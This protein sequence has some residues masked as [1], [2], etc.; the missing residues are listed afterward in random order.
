MNLAPLF[1][2]RLPALLALALSL[3]LAPAAVAADDPLGLPPAVRQKLQ[4]FCERFSHVAPDRKVILEPEWRG[5]P[6][7][8]VIFRRRVVSSDEK[9]NENLPMLLTQN[10]SHVFSG[11]VLKVDDMNP[12]GPEG[13]KALSKFLSEKA[14]DPVEIVLQ[15][16]KN[17]AGV[18]PG[19]M[20]QSA[21]IGKLELEC[22]VTADGKFF[23]LGV[24]Y[25]L[26]GDPRAERMK[27]LKLDG[28]I[29]T[30]PANAPVTIVEFSD[31]ECPMCATRQKDIEGVLEKY[32][33]KV[34]L[35]H[36]D[37]PIWRM[38]DW[39]VTA[40][41][42]SLCVEKVS[43]DAYWKYKKMLYERQKQITKD[44]FEQVMQPVVE[45]LGINFSE[46][47][48]CR[49]EARHRSHILKDLSQS[50]SNGVMSTPTLWVNGIL[51]DYGVDQVLD[52][53]VAQALAGK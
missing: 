5:A 7:G 9:F 45:S 2:R 11:Q 52:K 14:A 48:R 37:H 16:E 41:D 24:F 20:I 36:F 23:M 6:S 25:P 29:A 46:W 42:G 12:L 44:N 43:P 21:S 30:G 40:A 47:N 35:I 17:A 31:Y 4:T 53:T 39:A 26:D 49:K 22:A 27:R 8:F 33:G 34:R 18:F 28:A 1:R 3:P 50:F 15:K 51:I 32:K 13:T 38:H 10:Y 19:K